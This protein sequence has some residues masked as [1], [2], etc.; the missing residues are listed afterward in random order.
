MILVVAEQRDEALNRASWEAIAAAQ[1]MAGAW[2]ITVLA[3]GPSVGD[4]AKQLAQADVAEVLTG[5]HAALGQYTPDAFTM[6]LKGVI[7]QRKPAVVLMAHT[8]QARDFAPMLAARLRVTLIT[9][10]IGIN[11]DGASATFTR[12][13]DRPSSRC[14]LAR[15][16]PTQSGAV[17]PRRSP[18]SRSPST[19]R[20]SDSSQRRRS[21][22]PSRR[23]I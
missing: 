8:Y 6:A 5:E 1:Q 13:M 11:G 20:R 17:V 22:K 15:S 23:W 9:D 14:R 3:L 10:V 16:A 21:R 7:D 18:Q 12:P 2:P 19:Q 4:V